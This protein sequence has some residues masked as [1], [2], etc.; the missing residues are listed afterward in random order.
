G[1]EGA[2]RRWS[3]QPSTALGPLR[4]KHDRHGRTCRSEALALV[5]RALPHGTELPEAVAGQEY[6]STRRIKTWFRVEP[7]EPNNA[8]PHVKYADW[9]GGKKRSGGIWAH[10]FFLSG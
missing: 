4:S 10:I 1:A 5:R 7:V 2:G 3:A 8:L 6:G 9:I